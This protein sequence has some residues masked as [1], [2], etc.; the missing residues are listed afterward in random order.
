VALVIG[1]I[2]VTAILA[3]VS[4]LRRAI[5]VSPAETLRAE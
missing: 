1:A 4:P 3:S 5:V 2:A